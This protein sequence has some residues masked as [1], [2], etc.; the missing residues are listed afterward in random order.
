[1]QIPVEPTMDY[2]IPESTLGP[3]EGHA[4]F[5]HH[6]RASANTAIL[7]K[8]LGADFEVSEE[9]NERAIEM[10]SKLDKPYQATRQDNQ[11]LKVP[12]IVLR[13]G[14]YINEYEKQIVQD[15][16][17]LRN[18]AINR[19]LELSQ[20]D[21]EKVVLKA[22]ELIGKASDLFTERSEV[23]ITHKNSTELKDAIKD[24]IRILMQMNAVDVI[25]KNEL[26]LDSLSDQ[27]NNADSDKTIEG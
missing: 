7:L 8:E 9:E 3:P 20:S 16:V 11:N 25:P 23:T 5:T 2:P 17:Q 4:D 19:L 24:R 22:V 13:L 1:M 27:E 15:K 21:D 14:S 10:F 12:G 6:A 26:L 18:L